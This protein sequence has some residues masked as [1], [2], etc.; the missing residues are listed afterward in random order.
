MTPS[1]YRLIFKDHKVGA[2]ILKDMEKRFSQPAVT[3]GGVDA[4]IKTYQRYGQREVIDF[5]KMMIE[6]E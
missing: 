5:I 3:D 1:D 4:V 2:S 6:R